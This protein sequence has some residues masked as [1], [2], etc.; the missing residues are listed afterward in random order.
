MLSDLEIRL[1]YG[2]SVELLSLLKI[3]GIGRVRAR[4]LYDAG[5]RS[6]ESFKPADFATVAG[7]IGPNVADKLYKE[8]GT[9]HGSYIVKETRKSFSGSK[10]I[11][12]KGES[13]AGAEKRAEAETDFD[14][15]ASS[16]IQKRFD[17]Y[18]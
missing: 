17:D 1:Q 2:A 4:R 5:F 14:K 15:S 8:L 10:K 3:R 9:D 7:L 11:S 13:G 6:K 12:Q 18:F 16:Q